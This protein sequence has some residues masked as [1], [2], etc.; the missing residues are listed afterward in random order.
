M[1]SSSGFARGVG[2]VTRR[3]FGALAIAGGMPARSRQ[4]TATPRP[5]TVALVGAADRGKAVA[6]ALDLL[7]APDFRGRDVFIKASFNSPDPFPATTHPETLARVVEALRRCN[8]GRV[9]VVER[10]GM[11]LAA[12]VWKALGIPELARRLDVALLPLDQLAPAEW[13]KAEVPDSHWKR[14]VELPRFL[15]DDAPVIQICGAKTHRFG[16]VFSASLKNSIGLLAKYSHD[17]QPYNYMQELHAS[18]DQRLMIAEANL[19]YSPSL[20]FLDAAQVFISGGPERG[21]LAA[22]GMLAVS[23]DRVAIDAVAVSILR[24]HGAGAA[25]RRTDIFEHDQ[26]RRAAEL[27]LGAASAE[28]ITLLT[29]DS[30]SRRAALP[31]RALLTGVTEGTKP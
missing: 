24:I 6:A 9:T 19:V 12:E 26:I 27:K 15:D 17:A 18:A 30:A 13:R 22:P 1:H 25:I 31:I 11:G 23:T 3:E 14:G 2:R 20:I 4:E 5:S 7:G 29:A 8:C 21:D 28:Q 16:G 10:S